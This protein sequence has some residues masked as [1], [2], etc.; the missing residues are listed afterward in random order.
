MAV[1]TAMASSGFETS[2]ST[3]PDP[4]APAAFHGLAGE[5]VRTI[6]PHS[7]AD[8]AALLVQVLVAFGSA[9]GRSA[10]VAV[11]ADRHYPNLFVVLVGPTAKG[12]K[13]T[14]WGHVRRLFALAASDWTA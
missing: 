13:G 6:E 14:S 12:R 8:P 1:T 2:S 5:I 3:W 9:A 10:Y 11:E 7:E 4:L